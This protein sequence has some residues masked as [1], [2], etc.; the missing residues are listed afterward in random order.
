[1]YI[2]LYYVDRHLDIFIQLFQLPYSMHLYDENKM[3]VT[4]TNFFLIHLTLTRPS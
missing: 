1:M 3:Y 4:D 2:G